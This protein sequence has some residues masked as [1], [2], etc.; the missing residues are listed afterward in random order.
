MLRQTVEDLFNVWIVSHE[1]RKACLIE[2]ANYEKDSF[3]QEWKSL[4]EPW[5]YS[6][7]LYFEMDKFS[8]PDYPRILV[9]RQPLEYESD[10]QLGELLGFSYLKDDYWDYRNVRYV[11][12]IILDS[13]EVRDCSV[14][15]EVSRNLQK[16][17]KNVK[18]LVKK[19][20]EILVD[21]KF[22]FLTNIELF[23]SIR[24]DDGLY[25]RL[26]MINDEEYFEANYSE[27]INDIENLYTNQDSD[28]FFSEIQEFPRDKKIQGQIKQIWIESVRDELEN[29]RSPS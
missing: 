11:A 12:S 5:I 3:D 21:N 29:D 19:W 14:W 26:D 4:I 28:K 22:P 27:Y 15:V 18:K 10:S 23:Y 13:E 1:G 6:L 17:E 24:V 8:L 7:D 25:M 16:S 2:S 20:R 9:S